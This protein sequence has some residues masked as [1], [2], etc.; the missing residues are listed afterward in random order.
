MAVALSEPPRSASAGGRKAPVCSHCGVLAEA[1]GLVVWEGLSFCCS[2]CRFVYQLIR[3]QGLERFYDLREGPQTPVP[4]GVFQWRNLEWMDVLCRESGGRFEIE[5]QGMSCIACVWLIRRVFESRA[6]ALELDVD[7]LGGTAVLRVRQEVFNAGEFAALLQKFGYQAGPRT[8]LKR[9]DKT[10]GL[11]V[12]MGVCGAL[13]MNAMLFTVP[14]YC[15]LQFG[16]GLPAF[17]LKGAMLCATASMLA[18]ASYF[19]R[20][21]WNALRMGCVHMDLPIAAGLLAAYGGSI[22]AWKA[23][24]GEGV[25]FDFVSVF[26]FLMLVGRWVQQSALERNRNRV[27]QAPES[28]LKPSQGEVFT[29]PAGAPVPVRS[30]LRSREAL[31]GMEWINGES[32]ARHSRYGQGVASG[33]INLSGGPLELEAL[34]NWED[35]L[36]AK[37]LVAPAAKPEVHA[38]VQRFI[39][40]YLICVLLVAAAGFAF[41]MARGH[42]IQAAL[43]VCVSVLVVSCPCASGVALPLISDLAA[44]GMREHGVFVREAGIWSRLLRVGK[45]VFDKT[46]TLTGDVLRLKSRRGLDT[47]DAEAGDALRVLVSRSMHPAATSL[48]E[49][50]GV[51]PLHSSG[52]D[53]GV[54]EFA[55]YGLEWRDRAGAVWRLGRATWVV[56]GGAGSGAIEGAVFGREGAVIA[57]F[58]FKEK[59]RPGAV[60]EV[61]A[62][63]DAGYEIHI[64]SGDH[65][66]R[67]SAVASDLGLPADAA[68]GAQTPEEKAAWLRGRNGLDSALMLGD[69]AN[70]SLAFSESLVTGTPAVDRGVLEQRADFYYL[71]RGLSGVRKLLEMASFKSDI[72]RRVLV[73]TTFY[74]AA[75]I[76]LA[77]SGRMHPLLASIVMPLSSVATLAIVLHAFQRRASRGRGGF[78]S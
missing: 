19:V 5:V 60:E 64:L 55:G 71:G 58:E 17:F 54:R 72:G 56:E 12:R 9:G 70:D 57:V 24:A 14:G 66:A 42:G 50:L 39:L 41:W 34:E 76:S 25:Y 32:E 30:L 13:A 31:L 75:V 43:Q 49:A 4:A 51:F 22:H 27:L 6:G 61:G 21:A 8:G 10:R 28:A 2:G 74:N 7:L 3:D 1:D 48:R 18:G 35:S 63:R 23:G 68:D 65:P 44:V 67:V 69:G 20:R 29:V 11:V 36:L 46:G 45:V 47:L 38:G 52:E 78:E 77:L 26:T 37:L 59:L 33:A 40:W 53:D 16:E 62:L 15:G 73:F